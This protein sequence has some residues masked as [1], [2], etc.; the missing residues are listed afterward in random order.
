MLRAKLWT[1]NQKID[2]AIAEHGKALI[3]FARGVELYNR[4]KYQ[5][6][7]SIETKIRDTR[8]IDVQAEKQAKLKESI[9]AM[10][11]EKTQGMEQLWKL[12]S[13]ITK[14]GR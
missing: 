1:L 2:L 8:R 12:E 11:Q 13:Q 4:K 9:E 10:M 7:A 5:R 14:E 3:A 6:T